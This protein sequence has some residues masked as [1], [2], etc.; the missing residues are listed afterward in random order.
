MPEDYTVEYLPPNTVLEF[1]GNKY[2]LEV[3]RVNN[4]IHV[5]HQVIEAPMRLNPDEYNE[6][7]SY[8]DAVAKSNSRMIVLKKLKT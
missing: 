6:L 4:Y 8:Y 5:H 1:K 3:E 7:C 2:S